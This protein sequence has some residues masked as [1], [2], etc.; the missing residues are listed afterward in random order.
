MKILILGGNGYLGWPTSLFFSKQGHE[1]SIVDNF[2]KKK[3][4][5]RI[6]L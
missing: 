6:W 3:N 1:V 2:V 5:A 4:G